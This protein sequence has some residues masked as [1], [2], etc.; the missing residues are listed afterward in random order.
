ML[1]FFACFEIRKGAKFIFKQAL[2]FKVKDDSEI[3]SALQVPDIW[4]RALDFYKA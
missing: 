2:T 4:D 1:L 3:T